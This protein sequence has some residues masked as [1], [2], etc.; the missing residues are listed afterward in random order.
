[1]EAAKKGLNANQLKIIAMISM[2]V[3]HLAFVIYPNYPTKWQIIL[4]HILGRMAAP[5]F[6]W[7]AIA[8]PMTKRNMLCD[9]FSL[10]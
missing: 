10:R 9:C 5:I 1:M 3:D 4:L 6:W 7:R 8:T 2:T